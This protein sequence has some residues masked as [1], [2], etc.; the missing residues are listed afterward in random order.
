[1]TRCLWFSN[2]TCFFKII[3]LYI[4]QFLIYLPLILLGFLAL[5]IY[6][7]QLAGAMSFWL[8]LVIY[9][10]SVV[11]F[12]YLY[13]RLLIS[14][15]IVLDKKTNP[16]EAIK[17]S[18]RATRANVLRLVGISL[19]LLI[20]FFISILPLGIG[21]I[22]SLPLLYIAYGMIYHRLFINIGR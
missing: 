7:L 2:Q 12:I 15:G 13:C 10:C 21:L 16:W 20:I 14:T 6:G 5:N 1:M 17:Q 11:G 19:I 9:L 18:F 22:W 3:G 8:A 4:L